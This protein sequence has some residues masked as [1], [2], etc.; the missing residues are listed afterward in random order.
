MKRY[1]SMRLHLFKIKMTQR[2]LGELSGVHYARINN[3]LCGR[4]VISEE[5]EEILCKALDLDFRSYMRGK[6]VSK[7]K[8]K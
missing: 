7:E 2:K 6:I 1:E 4:V 3:Y 5:Q 8:K